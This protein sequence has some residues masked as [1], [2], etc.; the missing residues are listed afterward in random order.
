MVLVCATSQAARAR[1]LPPHHHEGGRRAHMPVDWRRLL[2]KPNEAEP[3]R[4]YLQHHLAGY[5]AGSMVY[6]RDENG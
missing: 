1:R 4:A 5:V 3:A 6:P 2:Q